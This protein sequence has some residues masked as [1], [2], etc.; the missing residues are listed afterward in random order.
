MDCLDV[1]CKEVV[2][3]AI[4]KELTISTA[5]SFTAGL[6]A[7]SIARIPGA[8][9]VLYGG[10]VTYMVEAKTKFLDIPRDYIEHY[11]VVSKNVAN[12]MAIQIRNKT[13]SD[14]GIGT[15][16][17]AGPGDEAGHVFVSIASD[18]KI[19]N[20]EMNLSLSR[21]MVRLTASKAVLKKLLSII[22]EV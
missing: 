16:G 19:Y 11:G 9:N 17:Y 18:K 10:A 4:K 7:S 1:L 22:R 8:S 2:G 21:N 20:L 15:T 5:E 3:T 12:Q 14:F 6:I 13:G